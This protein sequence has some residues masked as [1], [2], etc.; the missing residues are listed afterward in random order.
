MLGFMTAHAL[1]GSTLAVGIWSSV[2]R[3]R[4]LRW[5]GPLLIAAGAVGF[6]VHVVFS[7]SSRWMVS[8]LSDR[9][10]ITVSMVWGIITFSAMIVAAVAY[11][12]WFLGS[13]QS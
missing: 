5:V 7:M 2:G 11:G 9:M 12:G 13:V 8:S 4:S 6:F 1:L 3:S 10:H